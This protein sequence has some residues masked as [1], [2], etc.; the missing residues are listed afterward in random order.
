MGLLDDIMEHEQLG[1]PG[2]LKGY[3][4]ATMMAFASL[5]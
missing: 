2:L 5:E 4:V 1:Q 3:Q